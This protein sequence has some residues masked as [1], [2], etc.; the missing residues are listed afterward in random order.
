MGYGRGPPLLFSSSA[1]SL[2]FVLLWLLSLVLYCCS[3]SLFLYRRLSC[4]V[5][6][7]FRYPT[8]CT[9]E[10]YDHDRVVNAVGLDVLETLW[11]NIQ[12]TYFSFTTRRPPSSPPRRPGLHYIRLPPEAG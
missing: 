12:V 11:P 4:A 1:F 3:L 5:L 2:V 7:V 6:S 10:P 9:S 8:S